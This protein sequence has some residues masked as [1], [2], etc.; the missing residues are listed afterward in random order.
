MRIAMRGLVPL[1]LL[2]APHAVEASEAAAV[3]SVGTVLLIFGS[4][5]ACCCFAGIGA[6]FCCCRRLADYEVD[7]G[8]LE[9]KDDENR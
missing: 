9:V 6:Y 8:A 1:L 3:L 7:I 2:L 4:M 5:V